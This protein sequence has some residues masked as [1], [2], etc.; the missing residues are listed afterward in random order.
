M[1]VF[2]ILDGDMT[3]GSWQDFIWLWLFD[4]VLFWYWGLLLGEYMMQQQLR[5]MSWWF[6]PTSFPVLVSVADPSDH[7]SYQF[8]W[9]WNYFLI[10]RSLLQVAN[11]SIAQYMGSTG[12]SRKQDIS[13]LPAMVS[14][15]SCAEPCAFGKLP[16]HLFGC[17]RLYSF[18]TLSNIHPYLRGCF[19]FTGVNELYSKGMYMN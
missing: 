1:L 12:W 14:I 9:Q 13:S 15:V 6:P 19:T 7:R 10:L 4:Y 5:N 11:L 3:K 17:V 8:L 16:W 2:I 18:M